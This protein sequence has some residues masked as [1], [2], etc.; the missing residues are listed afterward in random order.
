MKQSRLVTIRSMAL[1]IGL[2]AIPL[3]VEA[4]LLERLFGSGDRRA[5]EAAAIARN[6]SD[7]DAS[8]DG[9]HMTRKKRARLENRYSELKAELRRAGV[10]TYH[11]EPKCR[12]TRVKR[13]WFPGWRRH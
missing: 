9:I 8:S 11:P 10:K 5:A 2:F 7:S 13:G 12:E 6:L 3:N 1:T 4:G